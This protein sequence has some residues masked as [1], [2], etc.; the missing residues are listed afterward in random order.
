MRK[1]KKRRKDKRKK[2]EKKK[3][4]K[5]GEIVGDQTANWTAKP[6]KKGKKTHQF[7]NSRTAVSVVPMLFL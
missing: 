5:M 1:K 6:L 3:S 2:E 4:E 7:W